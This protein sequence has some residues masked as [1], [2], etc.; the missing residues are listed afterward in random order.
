M[1]PDRDHVSGSVGLGGAG[2]VMRAIVS[3]IPSGLRGTT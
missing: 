2:S 1:P 3:P